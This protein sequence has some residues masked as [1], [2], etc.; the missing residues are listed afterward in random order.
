M[1]VYCSYGEANITTKG[2][3]QDSIE[4]RPQYKPLS[5]HLAGFYLLT[6]IN[7]FVAPFEDLTDTLSGETH[8]TISAVKPVLQHLCDVLLAESSEDSELTKEIKAT[9][10]AKVLQQY[11]SSDI[12]KLLDIATFLDPRFKHY[13]DDDQ[14]KKEI[15]ELVKLE[16]LQI[17][18]T[19]ETASE[20]QAIDNDE[21]PVAKNQD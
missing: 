8:V 5:N 20:I 15:E 13:K 12:N 16:V 10:K 14:Q 2:S 1:G 6:S 21:G 3:N 18:G 17:V 9:C 7:T 19:V 11:G 4:Q